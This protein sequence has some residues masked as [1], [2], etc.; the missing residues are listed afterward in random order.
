MKNNNTILKERI[1]EYN[2]IKSIRVGDYI[3]ELN[4][5]MSRVTHIWKF[6]KKEGGWHIQNG[7]FCRS[8]YL[9]YGYC[10]YSGSLDEGYNINRLKKT[11]KKKMGYIWFFDN[12]ISGVGRGKDFKMTFRVWEVKK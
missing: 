9:G 1:R 4:G 3:E 11:N 6:S 10:S 8:F 7:G 2:K 12:D 5:K